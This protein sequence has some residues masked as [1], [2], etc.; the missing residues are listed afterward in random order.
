MIGSETDVRYDQII[1]PTLR[2]KKM[3]ELKTQHHDKPDVHRNMKKI[4]TF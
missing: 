2:E 3:Y 1:G 4:H